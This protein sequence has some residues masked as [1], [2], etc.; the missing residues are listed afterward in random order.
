[1]AEQE[2]TIVAAVQ[3]KPVAAVPLEA[4]RVFQD[5]F[6]APWS[7]GGKRACDLGALKA[8]RT[9]V[10]Q[11]QEKQ[12]DLLGPLAW[13]SYKNAGGRFAT[14]KSFGHIWR[15]H[16]KHPCNGQLWESLTDLR[17]P[18]EECAVCIESMAR[19]KRQTLSCRHTFHAACIDKLIASTCNK[20]CPTCRH[21][22]PPS[23]EQLLRAKSL[24]LHD[25]LL[26]HSCSCEGCTENCK[27]MKGLVAHI[28][29]HNVHPYCDLCRR[30]LALLVLHSRGCSD[31]ECDVALCN[32][33]RRRQALQQEPPR[34]AL[35][36]M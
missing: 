35:L 34:V 7:A 8:L 22:L 20:A 36:P 25:R 1:M 19:G 27:R 21:P 12:F 13:A 14:I 5:Y 32:M 26:R 3:L 18:D 29:E 30:V 2:G 16:T 4:Q 24:E 33:L 15:I 11:L 10:S 31:Q 17:D 28:R 23:K 6:G 9:C